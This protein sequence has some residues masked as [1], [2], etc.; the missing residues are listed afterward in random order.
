MTIL[1]TLVISRKNKSFVTVVASS[2]SKPGTS[3][4]WHVI[5]LWRCVAPPPPRRHVATPRD[6][7]PLHIAYDEHDQNVSHINGF[8]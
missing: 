7:P 4:G 6:L 2:S 3:S 5:R 8:A 1:L